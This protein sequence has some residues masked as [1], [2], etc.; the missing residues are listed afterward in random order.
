MALCGAGAFAQHQN[1]APSEAPESGAALFRRNCA[2]CHGTG[3]EGGRAP[4]LTGRLRAGDEDA[5][6][7]RTV[8]AGLPG[9]DMGSYE[10]RL[11]PEKIRR[12]VAYLRSVK[13]SEPP[14]SGDA[15]RGETI[16]WGKGGCGNCHAV[17]K[18]GNRIGPDLSR[19]GRQRSVG[20]LRESLLAPGA[21]IAPNY[22]GV[23]V[24]TGDGKTVRGIEKAIDTFSV[25]LQDFTGKVYS[26]DRDSLRSVAQDR[27]SL[28]PE[29]GKA[30]APGEIDDVLTYLLTL[31]RSE[32][33]P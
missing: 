33:R 16:F 23:T 26:F 28:M 24:V 17:A 25:V 1:P 9:T 8:S 21:D 22:N 27:Q 4:S 5:D 12:I 19:I 30:L 20:Y 15:A 6:V 32:D 14:M 18:R 31:N 7:I 2:S 13:R 29:Y 10:T 3:G 11:G